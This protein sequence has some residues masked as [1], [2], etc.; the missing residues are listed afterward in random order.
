MSDPLDDVL[1][2]HA[3]YCRRLLDIDEKDPTRRFVF[4]HAPCCRKTKLRVRD[5]PEEARKA[6]LDL[7]AVVERYAKPPEASA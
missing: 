6:Y 3:P 7:V 2:L 4:P 1:Y 5:L